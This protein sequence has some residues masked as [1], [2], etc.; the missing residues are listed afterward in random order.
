[1]LIEREHSLRRDAVRQAGTAPIEDDDAR[2]A[3]ERLDE[4]HEGRRLP[5]GFDVVEHAG[6]DDDVDGRVADDLVRDAELAVAET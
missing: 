6:D 1:L 3:R 2:K 5:H 4:A